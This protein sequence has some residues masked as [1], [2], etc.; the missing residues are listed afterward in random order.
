MAVFWLFLVASLATLQTNTQLFFTFVI[1]IRPDHIL[2]LVAYHE[3][4]A[5]FFWGPLARQ[6]SLY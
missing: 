4:R 6:A 1:T 2:F 5:S 3:K